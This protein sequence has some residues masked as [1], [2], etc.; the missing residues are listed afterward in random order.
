ML[1][2]KLPGNNGALI[3]GKFRVLTNA[4]YKMIKDALKNYDTV[5]IALVSNRIT[6]ATKDL[7]RQMLEMSFQNEP[8][9][10]IVE[11]ISGNLATILNK[12]RYNINNIIVGTDRFQ[13]FKNQIKKLN[14]DLNIKEIKRTNDDISATKVIQNINDKEYFY[15][16]TPKSIHPLYNEIKNAYSKK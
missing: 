6:K 1:I 4:H 9:L 16:N 14:L 13:D 11:T 12:C 5:S 7:R 10:E 3:I 8:N 2:K 15:N